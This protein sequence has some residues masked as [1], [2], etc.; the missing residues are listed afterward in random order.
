MRTTRV[1]FL[2]KI[3][4]RSCP[5]FSVAIIANV[6]EKSAKMEDLGNRVSIGRDRQRS[7]ISAV[8]SG[9]FLRL[10]GGLGRFG[11]ALDDIHSRRATAKGVGGNSHGG[12]DA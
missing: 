7:N 6:G 11:V 10:R 8:G 12:R 1:F 9:G 5:F 2:N 4:L 3:I